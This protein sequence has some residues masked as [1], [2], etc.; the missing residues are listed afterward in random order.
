MSKNS[1]SKQ[2]KDGKDDTGALYYASVYKYTCLGHVRASS[3]SSS[4]ADDG[5]C[6]G[7]QYGLQHAAESR[8]AIRREQAI[9]DFSLLQ[10][11][12]QSYPHLP[13]SLQDLLKTQAVILSDRKEEWKEVDCYGF[14][15]V[16]ILVLQNVQTKQSLLTAVAPHVMVG[17]SIRD[18]GTKQEGSSLSG[19]LHLGPLEIGFDGD[20]ETTHEDHEEKKQAPLANTKE[21]ENKSLDLMEF[22]IKV[23][24]NMKKGAEILK[25]SVEEDFPSRVFD[26]GQRVVGQVGPTIQRTEK[27]ARAVF[28]VWLDDDDDDE[29]RS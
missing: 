4:S 28:R 7:I 13:P 24:E 23:G 29:S 3:S 16:E 18:V 5:V 2:T 25:H 17:N 21:T 12:T 19:T 8:R 15:N 14:T 9:Q 6:R 10:R 1:G 27:V 26:A 22:S 11:S 20:L